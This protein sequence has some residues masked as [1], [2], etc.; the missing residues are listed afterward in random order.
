VS[1]WR[2]LPA[3]CEL[4]RVIAE[5]LGWDNFFEGSDGVLY[6]DTPDIRANPRRWQAS[7]EPWSTDANAALSL[8]LPPR[9]WFVIYGPSA[10]RD[11]WDVELQDIGP[12][13]EQGQ[14]ETPALAICRAWLA[15]HDK[16][17]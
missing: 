15:W 7:V 5:A 13:F 11:T 10:E 9:T 3:G 16:Q 14:A 1:D 4:D 8:P 12:V 17:P 2:D 6:A